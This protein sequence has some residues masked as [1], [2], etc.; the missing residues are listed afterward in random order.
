MRRILLAAGAVLVLTGCA[1]TGSYYTTSAVAVTPGAPV[2]VAPGG[3]AYGYRP[4]WG[5]PSSSLYFSWGSSPAWRGGHYGGWNAWGPAYRP[6]GSPPPRYGPWGP[7]FGPK[8]HFRG[9]YGHGFG[10]PW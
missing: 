9:G 7:G 3:Y 5:P 10:R 1:T 8:P 4:G 2:Y 6:W